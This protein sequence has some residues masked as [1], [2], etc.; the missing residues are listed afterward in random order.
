MSNAKIESLTVAGGGSGT[1]AA[2]GAVGL[3]SIS[4]T[5]SAYITDGAMTDV[6]G[7]L[8]LT[9]LDD[10]SITAGAGALDAAGTV[11]I[12]AGVATN[13][14][15]DTVTAYIDGASQVQTGSATIS[16]TE[17]ANIEAASIGVSVSADVAVT[18]AVGVNEIHN[19]TDAHISAGASVSGG[20]IAVTAQD[21]SDNS[22]LTGQAAGSFVGI[23][24]A[25]SYNVIG[26]HVRAYVQNATVSGG[27]ISI[28]ALFTATINTITAGL[29]GGVVAVGGSVAVNL[30]QSDVSSLYCCLRGAGCRPDPRPSGH[31]RSAPGERRRR[32]RRGGCRS[33]DRGR[34]HDEQHARAYIEDSTVGSSTGQVSVFANSIEQPNPNGDGDTLVAVN[35]SGGL[36]GIGGV[37]SVNTVNDITQAFIASSQINPNLNLAKDA[38]LGYA[39]TVRATS[40]V[41]LQVISGGLSGGFVGASGTIDRT[42]VS[43]QTSAFIS[44]SDESGNYAYPT[45]PS[46]VY[47]YNVSVSTVSTENIQRT[48]VGGGFGAVGVSGAVAVLNVNVVNSAFVHDSDI[49][50]VAIFPLQ[51]VPMGALSITANDTT[52]VGTKVGDLA[53]GAV[54]AG[55]SINVN[56]IQN[57]VQ[58]QVL[59]GHLNASAALTV[60]ATSN[61]SITPLTGT[62]SLGAVA[63]A[64]AHHGEHDRN[65]HARG[66][67]ERIPALPHQPGF[68]VSGRRRLRSDF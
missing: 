63:L 67:R 20:S 22:S 47:A 37:V 48:I 30:L 19:T 9:A 27:S 12:S 49:Y 13:D 10:P 40:Q 14:I 21:T 36:V 55:A 29:S 52:T 44:S 45:T 11:A 28:H 15:S 41:N 16:A 26:N 23:G 33:G 6:L 64:G 42:T 25:I 51:G 58:A 2:G 5:T 24:G 61:E 18:G 50:A 1:F 8:T 56:T 43:G 38:G 46:I 31:D 53:G 35:V 62:G 54:G 17:D 65:D 34:E 66:D 32:Q 60:A 4:D 57:T 59:G 7:T 3:N 39:V 68:P